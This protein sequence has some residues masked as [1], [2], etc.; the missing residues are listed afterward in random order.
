[1]SSRPMRVTTV[2]ARKK[3]YKERSQKKDAKKSRPV[4]IVIKLPEVPFS[5][6]ESSERF[7]SEESEPNDKSRLVC[8]SCWVSR[9]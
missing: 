2:T 5:P 9:S 8:S 6:N 3:A 7:G 4:D 1:M